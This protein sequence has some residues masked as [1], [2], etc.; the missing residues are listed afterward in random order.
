MSSRL[1]IVR[2]KEEKRYAVLL[3]LWEATGGKEHNRVN[4]DGI[5]REAGLN[6]EESD[7]VYTYLMYEGLF[8]D[9]DTG[10]G[11]TLSHRA[12]VEIE[13]S[14]K[15]PNASTEHFPATVIQHFNAPVGSVQTGSQSSASVTQNIGA[16]ASDV[17][18][19]I[20]ELRQSIYTLPVGQQEE[21]F[22]VV[23]ALEE[24][25]QLPNPRKGRIRAFLTQLGTVATDIGVNVAATA[26][27]KYYGLDS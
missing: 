10:G 8:D 22:E 26:I 11:V 14:I 15:Q 4:F 27:A 13:Q 3:K 7:E 6:K 12:I 2:E 25:A 21:A 16:S 1:E 23:D 19:L 18:N 9:R 17:L 5:T 20:R 24:E